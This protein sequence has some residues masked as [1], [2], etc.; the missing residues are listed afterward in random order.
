MKNVNKAI[1]K[2][3]SSEVT[4][5]FYNLGDLEK[6]PIACFSDAAFANLKDGGSQ[7]AFIIFLYGNK[8]Y[9]SIA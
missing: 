6:S 9:A 4:L 2:L 8:K 1:Q 7:G 3:K 5:K